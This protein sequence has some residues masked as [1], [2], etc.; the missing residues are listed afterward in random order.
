MFNHLSLCQHLTRLPPMMHSLVTA[1][2]PR[3][4]ENIPTAVM[5]YFT[6]YES[7]TL[8]E[9]TYPSRPNTMHHPKVEIVLLLP[10]N[11][12]R[13]HLVFGD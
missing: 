11:F 9:A 4:A 8:T 3:R 12:V 5:F 13:R 6:P 2:K 1:S 10:H 7:I